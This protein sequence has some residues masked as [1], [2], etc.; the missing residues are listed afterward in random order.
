MLNTYTPGVYD[1]YRIQGV[2]TLAYEVTSIKLESRKLQEF[3]ILTREITSVKFSAL[4]IFFAR[5][6]N[7]ADFS[8]FRFGV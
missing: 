5:P 4:R 6:L 3:A 8:D 2:G 7:L 1:Q